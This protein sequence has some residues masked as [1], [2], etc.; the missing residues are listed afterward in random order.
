[1]QFRLQPFALGDLVEDE[2]EAIGGG[3]DLPLVPALGRRVGELKAYGSLLHQ[4]LV[5]GRVQR[6]VDQI[7]KGLPDDR[8]K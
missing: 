4:S 1:M 7:R 6:R 2:R 8:A 5:V 3:V